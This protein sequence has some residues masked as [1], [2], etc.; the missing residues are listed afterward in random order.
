MDGKRPVPTQQQIKLLHQKEIFLKALQTGG[1]S[2]AELREQ[3]GISFPAVSALVLTV[4]ILIF[5]EVTPKSL[6]KEHCRHCKQ[7]L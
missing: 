1:V 2:R 7:I 5:G 6:A 4:A 3:L